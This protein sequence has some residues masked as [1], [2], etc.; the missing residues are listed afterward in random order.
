VVFLIK[1]HGLL[2]AR[3]QWLHQRRLHHLGGLLQN[4]EIVVFKKRV[5]IILKNQYTTTCVGV[6]A[7]I[8]PSS[9]PASASL[10]ASLPSS[11][12]VI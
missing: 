9:S 12:P 1:Q 6:N 5:K 4:K 7:S 10:P 2:A 8:S 11:P 3:P